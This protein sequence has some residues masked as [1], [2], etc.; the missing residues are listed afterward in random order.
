MDAVV[1]K[2]DF[3]SNTLE[4]AAANNPIY[5]IRKNE[6][7]VLA[8]QKMPI[9][10]SDIMDAFATKSISIEPSDCI[11]TI[12]DGFADQFGGPKGKK[13]KYKQLKELLVSINNKSMQ[14]HVNILNET[15]ENWKGDLEQVDDVCVIGLKI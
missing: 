3:E 10:Y 14:S 12:T 2:I 11:Y 13:F 9:G 1:C 8:A 15:F 7:T 4:Y 5:L 6:L